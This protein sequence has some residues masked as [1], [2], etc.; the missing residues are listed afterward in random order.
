MKCIVKARCITVISL[1]IGFVCMNDLPG[2]AYQDFPDSSI[3]PINQADFAEGILNN[4]NFSNDSIQKV[5]LPTSSQIAQKRRVGPRDST[6]WIENRAGYVLRY[7]LVYFE[8]AEID[9]GGVKVP[10]PKT[11]TGTLSLGFDKGLRLPA[12]AKNARL[13]VTV[14]G[15]GSPVVFDEE[16]SP[17]G[18]MCIFARGTIFNPS[19]TK[20][21]TTIATGDGP[22]C[23]SQ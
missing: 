21:L 11:E 18:G 13:K 23:P 17:S 14:V 19:Y 16:V 22:R 10:V 9:M 8:G 7:T 3:S 6:I 2:Y 20:E 1:G 5:N 4:L 15:V 12:W